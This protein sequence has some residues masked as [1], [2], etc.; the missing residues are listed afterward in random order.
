MERVPMDDVS[1]LAHFDFPNPDTDCTPLITASHKGLTEA[2][3]ATVDVN[4]P[5]QDGLN[6]LMLAVRDIDLFERLRA[7]LPAEYRPV[8]VIKELLK[9]HIDPRVCDSSGKSALHYAAQLKSS[10]K[11]QVIQVLVDLMPLSDQQALLDLLTFS[12]PLANG[13]RSFPPQKSIILESFTCMEERK[14]ES[15]EESE[16]RKSKSA[17]AKTLQDMSQA[18]EELAEMSSQGISLPSLWQGYN[19]RQEHASIPDETHLPSHP[20]R[21][22]G[23]NK[24]Q[25]PV[26]ALSKSEPNIAAPLLRSNSLQDIKAQIQQRIFGKYESQACKDSKASISIGG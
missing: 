23:R 24:Q 21:R 22:N 10:I 14:H 15:E 25:I 2:E 12:K 20:I 13:V 18:Y 11:E 9:N 6:A 19:K 5:N 26:F 17:E 4:V 8:E 3:S 7:L 16:C 1:D